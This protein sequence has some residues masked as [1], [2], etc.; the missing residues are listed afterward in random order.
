MYVV[1]VKFQI[2]P[3]FWNAF[4]DAILVNAAASLAD[5]PGCACFDVCEDPDA[6]TI[7][8][9]ELYS[10][11]A[12]FEVHLGARHYIDFSAVTADWVDAKLVAR[13]QRVAPAG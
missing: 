2:K 4:R 9:Y 6:S 10:D 13:Y 8:L 7:F 11:A 3:A 1:T 12:A 5:E